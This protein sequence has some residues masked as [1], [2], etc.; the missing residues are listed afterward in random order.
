VVVLAL[1]VLGA[2]DPTGNVPVGGYG[3]NDNTDP[4]LVGSWRNQHLIPSG[5]YGDYTRV[6]TTWGFHAEATCSRNTKSLLFSEGIEREETRYC[7][8]VADGRILS[9]TYAGYTDTVNYT[10]GFPTQHPDTLD[11]GGFLFSHVP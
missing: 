2:C 11:I 6:I 7:T 9:L 10:Y 4:Q 3:N 1:L 5:D 8:W